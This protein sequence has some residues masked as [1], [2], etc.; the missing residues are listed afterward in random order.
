MALT[1]SGTS[2]L[3]KP[4]NTIFMQTLL[5]TAKSRAVHFLGTTPSSIQENM[6]TTTATWRRIT[7][8]S[9]QRGTLAEQATTA[10]MNTRNASTLQISAPT[11]TALKYGNFVIL[12]EEADIINFNGQ[13]DKIVEVMGVD[14]G[15]YLDILQRTA[16]VACVTLIY[17][18]GVASEGAVVSK[19]TKASIQSAVNTLDKN[20]A[21]TFTPMTTGSQNFGTT[22]LMPGF[23]GITHPDV[24]IDITQL[25][26][27]KPA[28]TYAGQVALFM[29]EYGSMTVAGQT[30]RFVSGQNADVEADAGG[31]TGTTGLRSTTGTNIDTYTTLIYGREAFGSLGFGATM[32]DG[33][34]MAGDDV[35][36]IRLISKGL[37]SGGTSDPYEEIMTIAYKFWH[38]ATCLNTA[39][40]RG[41]VS[42]ATAL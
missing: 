2:T 41:I 8:N 39:W 28:E 13:T 18:G 22:Q 31:L 14:A 23:I 38:A 12:N 4:V 15:D 24:A 6:G 5:R 17:A 9:N 20:K 33:A 7:I 35:S 3:Q 19:I 16:E 30:V 36:A 40:A 11:A 29:G 32:P 25:A 42:G 21:L 26:G 10:Y 34:F 37:M 1:T 27:F